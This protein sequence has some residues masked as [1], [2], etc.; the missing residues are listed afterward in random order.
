MGCT[1]GLLLNTHPCLC[2]NKRRNFKIF[3]PLIFFFFFKC[4]LKLQRIKV[5]LVC[6]GK[7]FT[8]S[9]ASKKNLLKRYWCSA[10]RMH[11]NNNSLWVSPQLSGWATNAHQINMV[12]RSSCCQNIFT[13]SLSLPINADEE[14]MWSCALICSLIYQDWH[15]TALWAL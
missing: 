13:Q 9:L 6:K 4:K 10:H 5:N 14:N 11:E 15:G 12:S 7:R 1:G 8:I 3:K 2:K